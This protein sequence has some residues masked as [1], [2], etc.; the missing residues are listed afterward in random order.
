M[1]TR[2]ARPLKQPLTP[3]ET[4]SAFGTLEYDR[5]LESLR[6]M[7]SASKLSATRAARKHDL[8]LREFKHYAGSALVKERGRY[9]PKALDRLYREVWFVDEQGGRWIK[10]SSSREVEKLV[11]YNRLAKA[12]LGATNSATAADAAKRLQ[13]FARM[14]FRT[15]DEGSLSFVTNPTLLERLYHAGEL[16]FEQLYRMAS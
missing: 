11:A 1:L 9:R 10:P 8:T 5:S 3:R 2:R 4:Q 6:E 16:G 13:R 7:R 15:R 14:R 12:Y